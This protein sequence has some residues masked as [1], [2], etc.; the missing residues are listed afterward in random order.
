MSDQSQDLSHFGS[1]PKAWVGK[2]R[3][4]VMK[5]NKRRP[6]QE[7]SHPTTTPWSGTRFRPHA[8][9]DMTITQRYQALFNWI[10][11]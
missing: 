3:R 5:G 1:S 4:R 2:S 7:R 10:A 9:A 8:Y 11:S 6:K